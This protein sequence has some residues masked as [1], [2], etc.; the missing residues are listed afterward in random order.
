[1]LMLYMVEPLVLYG[2]TNMWLC[3]C[4]RCV[5]SASPVEWLQKELQKISFM[6]LGYSSCHIL[7]LSVSHAVTCQIHSQVWFH[8]FNS[9]ILQIA[10]CVCLSAV[11]WNSLSTLS[12]TSRSPGL[13]PSFHLHSQHS[14]PMMFHLTI[15]H[16]QGVLYTLKLYF[17]LKQM[18]TWH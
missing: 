15:F 11:L 10:G 7:T 6:S 18:F 13:C 17:L 12:S 16:W 8:S 5:R 4:M 1:M 3:L 9:I 2:V 14:F